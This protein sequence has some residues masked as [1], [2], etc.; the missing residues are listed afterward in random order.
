MLIL[1]LRALY[2]G[3]YTR[4]LEVIS[5]GS[6]TIQVCPAFRPVVVYPVTCFKNI[7]NRRFYNRLFL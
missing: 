6:D 1:K 4:Q 3:N 2:T 5:G 7:F